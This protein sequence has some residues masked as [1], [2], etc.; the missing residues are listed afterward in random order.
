MVSIAAPLF[1]RHS[2]QKWN[3]ADTACRVRPWPDRAARFQQGLAEEAIGRLNPARVRSG[4]SR[5]LPRRVASAN[6][7]GGCACSLALAD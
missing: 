2:Y 1:N 4:A 6:S 5:R 3:P 7:S